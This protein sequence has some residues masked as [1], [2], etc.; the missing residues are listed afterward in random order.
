MPK[1]RPTYVSLYSGCGG[2]DLGFEQSGYRGLG[3]FDI[4]E[5]AVAVHNRNLRSKCH[6]ANLQTTTVSQADLGC[7]D[8][9]IAGSPCQGFSNLGKRRTTDPRNSLL[10][11]GAC[12]AVSLRPKVIVLENVCGVLSSSLKSHWDDAVA[13]LEDACYSTVTWRLTSSDFGLP[14]IRKRVLLVAV[15][16]KDPNTMQLQSRPSR[17][18]RDCL[19]GVDKL[20][21]HEPTVLHPTSDAYKI[22]SHIRQHQKLCNVRGGERSVPT[23]E[24]PLVFGKT[25]KRERQILVEI[26]HLRRRIRIR[27]HGDADPLTMEI[28]KRE[29][30]CDS[31]AV[32]NTLIDKGY[33]RRISGRYDLVHTFN[34]KFRR[35]SLEHQSPAV[36]TRFG[37]PRYF[38]HPEENRGFSVR[39]AAR[40]QGFPDD[41]VFA[42]TLPVQFRLVGNAV[43]PPVAKAVAV[44]IQDAFL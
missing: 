16:D 8:V 35:L 5:D 15:R 20:S 18:L 1:S 24:I 32:V 12:L 33:M 30:G 2:F 10:Q 11:R 44:A 6:V 4:C 7:P 43:P 21:N 3:A 25:T 36:D 42:G 9:V 41:F 27:D 17:S 29:C 40:I 26:R 31:A 14:Q 19:D 37:T 34:G 39:E 28:I 23:W 22:A 13:I 38:L